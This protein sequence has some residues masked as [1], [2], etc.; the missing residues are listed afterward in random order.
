[1]KTKMFDNDVDQFVY[2]HMLSYPSICPTRESVL[3]HALMV[4][5][6]GCEWNYN[7]Q[8]CGDSTCR[9]L[10]E[11]IVYH[12]D[13]LKRNVKSDRFGGSPE[14]W[15]TRHTADMEI[16]NSAHELAIKKAEP[17]KADEGGHYERSM[18]GD[19]ARM[20]TSGATINDDWLAACYEVAEYVRYANE[21][22]DDMIKYL[23]ELSA[24]Q[25]KLKE[26]E[27]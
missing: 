23:D 22:Y 11:A 19:Y 3:V 15:E 12:Q 16:V 10:D 18:Y 2:N 14:F 25:K 24:A 6:N 9:T 20:F 21:S 27:G 13:E 7:G 26:K 4:I 17:L 8:L 5:G 1:M